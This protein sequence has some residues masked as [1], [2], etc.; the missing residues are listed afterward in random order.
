MSGGGKNQDVSE[1][2]ALSQ[3]SLLPLKDGESGS[4][5]YKALASGIAGL[6]ESGSLKPGQRLPTVRS[7]ASHLELSPGT[8]KH[9]YN[10]LESRE[11]LFLQQGRGTFVRSA[12]PQDKKLSRKE[13]AMEAIDQLFDQLDA[14]QLSRRQ[15]QIFLDLKLRERVSLGSQLNVLLLTESPEERHYMQG[16]LSRMPF[17][18]FYACPVED[19][20]FSRINAEDYEA[21]VC[22]TDCYPSICRKIRE[23]NI[24]ILPL[25]LQASPDT[26][27][28]LSQLSAETRL[29]ILSLSA[30]FGGKMSDSCRIYSQ[31]RE[32][33]SRFLF[34]H[35]EDFYALHDLDALLMPPDYFASLDE[36]MRAETREFERRGGQIIVYKIEEESASL[37]AV[38]DMLELTLESRLQSVR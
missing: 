21:V 11:L 9:A 34:S 22:S 24:P 17:C 18:D 16:C 7:L 25:G 28:A 36:K 37:A 30:T 14:L 35:M 4:V 12:M 32:T 23:K 3:I 8:V 13:Q 26:L 20:L 33:P 27:I 6:I 10:V 31:V 38:Q 1:A 15:I 19:F 29:G 5:V 2:E